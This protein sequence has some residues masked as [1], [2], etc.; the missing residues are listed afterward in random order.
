MSYWLNHHDASAQA[1]DQYCRSTTVVC[2]SVCGQLLSTRLKPMCRMK[3]L[4]PF[5]E[6]GRPSPI[7]SPL[8]HP[9]SYV[10][11]PGRCCCRTLT[12]GLLTVPSLFRLV[13]PYFCEKALTTWQ[14]G[15][16]TDPKSY[17]CK[18]RTAGCAS[19]CD[20]MT[21]G[22]VAIR[23]AVLN[24]TKSL[25]VCTQGLSNRVMSHQFKTVVQGGQVRFRLA[26]SHTTHQLTSHSLCCTAGCSNH[27][28]EC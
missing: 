2:C 27:N 5:V 11:W 25:Y 3:P 15:T 12:C 28:A 4:P 26:Q 8:T 18:A 21:C 14:A 13:T 24:S 19:G 1:P 10:A 22:Q 20:I 7:L 23:A 6:L 16:L 9:C 17:L